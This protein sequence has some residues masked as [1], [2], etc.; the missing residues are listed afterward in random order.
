MPDPVI[1]AG[2]G[3]RRGCTAAELRELLEKTLEQL[4]LPLSA[5]DGLASSAHKRGEAG[6]LQLAAGLGLTMDFYAAEQLTPYESQLSEGS[7]LV[8][9][10]TGSASVAEA[11]ALASAS[12]R[13]GRAALLICP[14]QRSAA[15]TLAI[16]RA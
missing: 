7:D 2:L 10:L 12:E 4:A 1:I 8:R 9:E 5:L 16:A 11:S 3:C 14:K 13:S 15:A 6:L